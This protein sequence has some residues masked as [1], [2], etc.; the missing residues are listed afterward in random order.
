M[1][2]NISKWS[3]WHS[4]QFYKNNTPLWKVFERLAK[5]FFCLNGLLALFLVRQ[6]AGWQGIKDIEDLQWIE[7]HDLPH[8]G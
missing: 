8:L 6:A 2:P 3:K 5:H 1:G 7:H 4:K